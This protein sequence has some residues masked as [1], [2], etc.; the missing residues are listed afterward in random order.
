MQLINVK[1]L[2]P[3]PKNEYFFDNMTGQKWNEF[4]ESVKTSGIIE[5]IV[6]TQDKNTGELIIISGH[7][8][9]RA[10]IELGI[11]EIMCDIRVY[12]NEVDMMKDL[13]ETNIR[14]RGDISSSSLKMGRIIKTLE[15]CY[16]IKRGGNGSNQFAKTD[17]VENSKSQKDI[18]EQLG[19]SV[20]TYGNA[21]KL[22]DLIPEL[23]ELLE[24][25]RLT[26]STASR[27]LA[28]LSSK[29]QKEV[30]DTIGADAISEMTQK[31]VKQY[32]EDN[33]RLKNELEQ[34]KNKPKEKEYIEK[35]VDNTDYTSC[36]A[37]ASHRFT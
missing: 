27:I 25:G 14:Q 16:G 8:R 11:E 2:K 31:Q 12:N 1:E 33:N 18:A 35:V 20:D 34:E 21:K 29:E 19:M 7:Q 5:P 17:N 13:I 24:Q 15:E 4:L 28:R 36:G 6:V 37:F 30:L 22:L 26:T 10:C 23:Q 32:I 3:H 9:T